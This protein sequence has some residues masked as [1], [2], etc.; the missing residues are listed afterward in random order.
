MPT[1]IA[2]VYEQ[3]VLRPTEPINLPE[4]SQVKLHLIPPNEAILPQFSW[5]NSL[6]DL[7]RFVKQAKKDLDSELLSQ[8]WPHILQKEL[9]LFWHI[10]PP[11]Q[12]RLGAMLELAVS[13][14]TTQPL[15]LVHVEAINKVITVLKQDTISETDMQSCYQTLLDAELPPSLTHDDN[16]VQSYLDDQ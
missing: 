8:T 4:H 9:R 10:A 11:A 5:H 7:E 2:A 6:H 14:L 15:T 1:A 3:G 16:L 12:Q 13:H